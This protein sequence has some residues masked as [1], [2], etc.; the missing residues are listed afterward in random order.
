MNETAHGFPRQQQPRPGHE[1]AMD[2]APRAEMEGYVGS[3]KLNGMRA[4]TGGDSG[5]G[6]AV[7]VAFAKEGADVAIAYLSEHDDAARTAELVDPS[8]VFFASRELSGY[9]SGEVL[10]PVGG[11]T[12][13]G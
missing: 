8:Y 10:A 13:P 12:L 3:G 11:E 1:A 6:R 4:L 9:Y 5:I 2:P 7:S